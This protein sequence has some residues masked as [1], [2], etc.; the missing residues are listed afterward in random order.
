MEEF[1]SVSNH[2][3]CDDLTLMEGFR[4]RLDDEIQIVILKRDSCWTLVEYINFALWVDGSSFA[5]GKFE[6]DSVPSVQLHLTSISTPDP[7]AMTTADKKP[8]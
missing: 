3:N 1:V 5:V 8:D 6:E 7:E 2:T 4:S